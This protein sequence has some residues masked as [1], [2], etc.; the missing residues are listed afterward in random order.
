MTVH[1]FP[2]YQQTDS[3]PTILKVLNGQGNTP[4]ILVATIPGSIWRY[5]GGGYTVM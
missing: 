1:G 2:G 3:F 5:S 4:A